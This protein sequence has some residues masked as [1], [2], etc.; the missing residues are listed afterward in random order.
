[1]T[2]RLSRTE[3]ENIAMQNRTGLARAITNEAN[4]YHIHFEK[5]LEYGLQEH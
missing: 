2:L 5:Y 1:M 3:S 4:A